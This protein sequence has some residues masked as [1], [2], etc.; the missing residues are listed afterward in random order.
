MVLNIATNAMLSMQQPP[1]TTSDYKDLPT[2]QK[3]WATWKTLYKATQGKKRIRAKA[4]S[5]MDSFGGSNAG[6]AND[7]QDDGSRSKSCDYAF[8]VND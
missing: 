2:N 5:G 3:T 4:A 8:T 1:K 6:G 7:A